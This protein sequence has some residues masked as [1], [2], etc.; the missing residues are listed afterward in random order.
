MH[1]PTEFVDFS[2]MTPLAIR[3]AIGANPLVRNNLTLSTPSLNALTF[4]MALPGTIYAQGQCNVDAMNWYPDVVTK[5]VSER[6]VKPATE[7]L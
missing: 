7:I 4:A 3:L 2:E 5:G 1:S 6:V